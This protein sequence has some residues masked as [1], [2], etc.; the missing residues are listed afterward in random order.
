MSHFFGFVEKKILRIYGSGS[1]SVGRLHC[2]K[3][4]L[5]KNVNF[6]LFFYIFIQLPHSLPLSMQLPQTGQL[7]K[8]FIKFTTSRSNKELIEIRS[9]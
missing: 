7:N 4:Y 6:I 5:Q 8:F 1:F 2:V 3:T 9:S